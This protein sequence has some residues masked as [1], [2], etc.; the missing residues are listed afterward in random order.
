[1]TSQTGKEN[2]KKKRVR[3]L[4]AEIV[5]E[6]WGKQKSYSV[7]LQIKTENTNTQKGKRKIYIY[8]HYVHGQELG[9]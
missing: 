3:I 6:V 9:I 8:I 2:P 5:K 7:H 1:L 4:N